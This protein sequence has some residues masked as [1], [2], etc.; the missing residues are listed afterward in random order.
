MKKYEYELETNKG[1]EINFSINEEI[2]EI[3]TE[4]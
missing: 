3:K 1:L 4:D 2:R